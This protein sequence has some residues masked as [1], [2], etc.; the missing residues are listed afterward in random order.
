MD[1]RELGEHISKRHT[2]S[3]QANLNQPLF[4][5]DRWYQLKTAQADSEQAALELSATKQALVLQSA[6]VYF[7][8]LR[9]QDNLAA[10]QA[11]EKAFERQ[12][13]LASARFDVGLSDKTDV[14]QALAAYDNAR[15]NRMQ[16]E[17]HVEDAL[18]ALETLTNHPLQTLQGIRHNLPIQPPAPNDAGAWVDRALADNLQLRAMEH[19]LEAA[20]HDLRT[21][22]AAHAPTLDAIA[23]YQKGDN[24]SLGFANRGMGNPTYNRHAEQSVI[25]LQLN[26][27]LYT[28]GATT[29]RVR[30]GVHQLHNA[31]HSKEGLR[32]QT[33][34]NARNLHRAVNTEWSRCRH[35]NRRSF[36]ARVRWRQPKLVMR[37]VPAPWLTC[38][39][40]S[41]SCMRRC[42]IT[43]TPAMTTF[44]IRC[45]CSK[46]PAASAPIACKH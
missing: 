4:R 3:Y 32:R 10:S 12:H 37:W 35:A 39:T 9:S 29:S 16:T 25:G 21:R 43:T 34:Q 22:K 24:D 20:Q 30:Q 27:P 7:A 38:W 41:A 31:E 5:L 1:T 33:V 2:Y 18:Q 19:T 26:I 14:Q 6:E 36:P 15:A 40:L 42:A 13:E 11:E 23:Q 8:I 46:P 28:G 44:S 45:V 17:Q